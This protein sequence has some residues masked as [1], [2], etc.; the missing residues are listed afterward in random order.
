MTQKVAENPVDSSFWAE[1]E[2]L[3]IL[4]VT[5]GGA[6]LGSGGAWRKAAA[7]G[8]LQ[9]ARVA[10]AL[11]RLDGG[12][13]VWPIRSFRSLLGWR[14][15]LT[16]RKTEALGAHPSFSLSLSLSQICSPE[17]SLSLS[18]TALI[19]YWDR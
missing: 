5:G 6:W 16:R 14:C 18:L 19:P 15:T 8:D 13:G 7:R 11:L 3:E 4:E 2:I 10:H 1:E 12:F 9:M 17:F